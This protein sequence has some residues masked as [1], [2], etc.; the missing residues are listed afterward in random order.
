MGVTPTDTVH[1]IA[2]DI[3]LQDNGGSFI[4]DNNLQSRLLYGGIAL[5]GTV[6]HYSDLPL[7]THAGGLYVTEDTGQ[8]Y[9]SDGRGGW[10]EMSI[11]GPRGITGPA[12][13]PGLT[14]PEGPTG[15][16]G[17]DGTKV[18]LIPKE[19]GVAA[20][21]PDNGG[22]AESGDVIISTQPQ[23]TIWQVL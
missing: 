1:P 17:R 9:V 18:W 14:G 19:A 22:P 20:M 23:L 4:Y 3:H 13:V 5:L 10:V 6:K 12:G 16:A 2:G 15:P 11:Q 21:D 8:G 7:G